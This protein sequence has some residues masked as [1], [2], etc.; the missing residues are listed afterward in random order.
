MSRYKRLHWAGLKVQN[1]NSDLSFCI[2]KQ[3]Q[4]TMKKNMWLIFHKNKSQWGRKQARLGAC[5]PTCRIS[6]ICVTEGGTRARGRDRAS[7]NFTLK[8][9][10]FL[11]W[12][13]ASCRTEGSLPC[14]QERHGK[15]ENCLKLSLWAA[16]TKKTTDSSDGCVPEPDERWPAALTEHHRRRSP[17]SLPESRVTSGLHQLHKN[18][19]KRQSLKTNSLALTT[20]AYFQ[21][22][23]YIICTFVES[24]F[25]PKDDHAF[26][27]QLIL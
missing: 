26:C 23:Y 5:R 20:P 7:S 27:Q 17:M 11:K 1:C 22:G 19:Q 9:I 10:V 15:Q 2:W 14:T 4:M 21:T 25:V 24:Y 16:N 6:S 8:T 18:K 12:S 3:S 13:R